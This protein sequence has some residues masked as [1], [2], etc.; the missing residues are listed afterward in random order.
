MKRP[1]PTA[2]ASSKSSLEK[3]AAVSMEDCRI[4]DLPPLSDTS[5]RARARAVRS[6]SYCRIARELRRVHECEVPASPAHVRDRGNT[7]RHL[8]ALSFNGFEGTCS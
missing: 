4:H 2:P 7:G 8:F 3:H 5:T 1:E 6:G